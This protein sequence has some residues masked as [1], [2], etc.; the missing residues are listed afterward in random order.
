MITLTRREREVMFWLANGREPAEIALI[1]QV[2]KKR[3][4]NVMYDTR[5]KLKAHTTAHAIAICLLRGY[6]SPCH[7]YDPDNAPNIAAWRCS[8]SEFL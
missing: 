2:S 7:I 1:L 8:V 4:N 3:V 6:L 5:Q